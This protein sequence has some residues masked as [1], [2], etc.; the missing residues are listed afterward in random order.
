MYD[1]IDNLRKM[2]ENRVLDVFKLIRISPDLFDRTLCLFYVKRHP[3][4]IKNI[5]EELDADYPVTHKIITKLVHL[6]MLSVDEGSRSGNQFILSQEGI[7]FYLN[8][9][10]TELDN[11]I[12]DVISKKH[13]VAILKLLNTKEYSWTDLRKKMEV[14]ES[15]MKSAIDE[16]FTAGLIDK[17]EGKYSL[18][19][20]G[21]SALDILKNLSEMEFTPAFE[22]QIKML[23]ENPQICKIIEEMEGVVEK[24]QVK[25]T[26]HYFITPHANV[27][28]QSYLRLRSEVPIS[29]ASLRTLPEHSLTWTNVTGRKKYDN[30]WII[31]RQ[32]EEMDVRYPAIIF[33]LDFLGAK[34]HKK[35]VKKRVKM[36][37]PDK[38]I[39]INIDEIENSKKA[40][41]FLEVKTSAWNEDEA[42]DKTRVIQEVIKDIG[43]ENLTSMD[44]TYYELTSDSSI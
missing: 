27:K 31:S 37:I 1:L 38:Q 11:K 23:A 21:I 36:E 2:G 44:Q 28:D 15:S 10:T 18:S 9:S 16:L 19:E 40:G 26:D 34:V 4:S 13:S 29:S 7:D 17:M 41:I 24:E 8:Y 3:L 12:I 42:K 43:M 14:S 22:V 5:C 30:L 35:I 33:Y 6:G 32:K 20:G 25:Q 39:T